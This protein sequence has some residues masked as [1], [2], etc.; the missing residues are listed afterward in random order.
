MILCWGEEELTFFFNEAYFPLLGPRL[1]WAMGAPFH[2]VWA[3]AWE[4]AKPIIADAFDGR[5]QHY[6][7]LPWKLATDRGRAETWFSFSYSRVLD[8]GGAVAGLFISTVETTDRVLADEALRASERKW[9]DIFATLQEGFL[10]G[11]LIRDAAGTAIDWRYEEVNDA[12]HDLVAVPRGQAVGRRVREII[13]GI[14]DEWIAAFATVVE[15]GEPARFTQ[16]VGE[17]GRWYD[18]VAQSI[19]GDRFTVI[20]SDATERV[21]RLNRQ[22]GVVALTDVLQNASLVDDLIVSA[23][24][25]IGQTL[26][27]ELVGFGSVDSDAETIAVESDWATADALSLSGTHQFRD[28]GSYIDDLKS[29]ETVIVVDCRTDPR[30]RDH[31]AAFEARRSQAF[32]NVPVIERGRFVAL[33]YAISTRP[34][35]W[36]GED[37]QFLRDAAA[38]IRVAVQRIRA[39]E[40]QDILNREIVH[41]LKNTLA[42]VQSIANLTL[43]DHLEPGAL[44]IFA[45]RLTALGMA[46]NDLLDHSIGPADLG[47]LIGRVLDAVGATDRFCAKGPHVRLGQRS[48]LSTSLLIHELATNAMKYGALSSD[49]TIAIEWKLVGQGKDRQLILHWNERGGPPVEEPATKGFGSRLIRMGL[50]GTG[51]STLN[52]GPGGFNASFA[53]PIADLER[54]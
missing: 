3:D 32:V 33:L 34:R 46:Q 15:T 1:E 12:W 16:Q 9:R 19:G 41:R 37:L 48:A 42:M 5:S 50:A 36:S 27:I 51:G 31:I 29:G 38:R 18:C 49:G 45:R 53:A 26:G 2:E 11:E 24:A 35:S 7:D 52:Y 54:S 4:Q 17:L 21:D 14:E 28:Y 6:T 43:R 44:S 25:V 47:E 20:F 30:T 8:P 23:S 39:E 13:P 22:A 40:Q 10:I